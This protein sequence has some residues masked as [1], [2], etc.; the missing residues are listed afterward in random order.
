M[1][2]TS[3]RLTQELSKIEL[4]HIQSCT[5][6]KTERKK[7]MAL[8]VSA[9]QMDLMTP[10]P[11]AWQNL[12]MVLPQSQSKTNRFKQFIYASAASIFMVSIG[13]LMWSNYS[14]QQ[15]FEAVLSAN[16]LLETQL[17]VESIGRKNNIEIYSQVLS[18]EEELSSATTK[19]EILNN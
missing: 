8:K 13:W 9:N 6:C 10:P 14:L 11:E 17:L 7:L 19:K 16:K 4:L 1:H 3:D 2:I 12:A 18:I 5:Q 15:Q